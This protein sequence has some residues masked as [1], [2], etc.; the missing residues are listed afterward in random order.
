MIK[1][2]V[3]GSSTDLENLILT[4]KKQG[5]RGSHVVA[6]DEK[7]FR[8]LEDVVR[9]RRATQKGEQQA[10]RAATRPK[11]APRE[12]QQ[13]LRAGKPVDQVARQAGVDTAWIERFLGPVLDERAVAIQASR[14]ARLEKPRLG[15][16]SLPLGEAVARNLRARRVRITEDELKDAWDA[17]RSDSQP[18]VITLTFPYRGREQRAVWRFDPRT[19]EVSAGNRLGSDVGWVADRRSTSGGP[20]PSA[21]RATPKP[22]R[23]K[24]AGRKSKK[25]KATRKK[26]A[27]RKVARKKVAKRRTTPKRATKRRATPKRATKRRTTAR[28]PASRRRAR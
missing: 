26:T 17:S 25:A 1:L 24:A 2:R 22:A 21:R 15:L 8:T 5:R 14:R 11:L 9:K 4:S 18:W 28:R 27:T 10:R 20:R 23:K 7:L 16:S 12:I 13:L 3:V 6:I 19:G